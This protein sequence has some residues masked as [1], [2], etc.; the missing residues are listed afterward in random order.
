MFYA[1]AFFLKTCKTSWDRETKS[2]Y[3]FSGSSLY[4]YAH[5]YIYIYTC[6]VE[7]DIYERKTW[8]IHMNRHIF[9]L[10]K[11]TCI[12]INKLHIHSIFCGYAML[13]GGYVGQNSTDMKDR[14][15]TFSLTD[16]MYIFI[17]KVH[18]HFI[19]KLFVH[20]HKN[21]PHTFS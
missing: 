18:T 17:N 21:I 19:N 15:D 8:Q 13:F 6:R 12:F 4:A 16:Y 20:S 14:H 3:T 7:F 2:V 11:Y 5:M 1:H 10:T 9:A